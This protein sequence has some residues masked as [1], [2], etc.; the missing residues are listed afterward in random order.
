MQGFF[1]YYLGM[2][3]RYCCGNKDWI[4]FG[5]NLHLI[6]K[7]VQTEISVLWR[8]DQPVTSLKAILCRICRGSRG[9]TRVSGLENDEEER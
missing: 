9:E 2:S 4:Q 1:V 6:N 3:L 5:P 8:H 7:I